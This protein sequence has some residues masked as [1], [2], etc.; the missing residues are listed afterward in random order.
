[1]A[2]KEGKKPRKRSRSIGMGDLLRIPVGVLFI[3]LAVTAIRKSTVF[4]S[5]GVLGI[6]VFIL[7]I[8]V[9]VMFAA[10]GLAMAVGPLL[11]RKPR[12]SKKRQPPPEQTD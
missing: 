3:C 5:K 11:D 2:E 10:I 8:A 7:A 9:T 4:L 1:M 6:A 12:R